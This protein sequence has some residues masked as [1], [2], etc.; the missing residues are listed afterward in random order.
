MI[1]ALVLIVL[2]VVC[3]L[4]HNSLL[5]SSIRNREGDKRM[6][7]SPFFVSW[8]AF[9]GNSICLVVFFIA[10]CVKSS[11]GKE[12]YKIPL[13]FFALALVPPICS[14]IRT[15]IIFFSYIVL[16][17]VTKE[18]Q[19]G[20]DALWI[21]F[22]VLFSF[23]FLK[24][25]KMHSSQVV[26]ITTVIVGLIAV[27]VSLFFV[28]SRDFFHHGSDDSVDSE[29][30][31]SSSFGGSN[32]WLVALAFLLLVVCE[33]LSAVETVIDEKL[34]H[35]LKAPKLLVVGFEGFC[36]L[37]LCSF[38]SL[39]VV[40]H[41]PYLYGREDILDDFNIL[42]CNS[43]L[44]FMILLYAIL[45]V[46]FNI[47]DMFFIEIT[48]AMAHNMFEEVRFF[49]YWLLTIIFITISFGFPSVVFGDIIEL[50]GFLVSTFGFLVYTTA[51]KLP[52]LKTPE[53]S[54]SI[55]SD[56]KELSAAAEETTP[57]IVEHSEL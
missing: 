38:I 35:D 31:K 42:G 13:K 45:T 55:N 4:V 57:L 33:A 34:L 29:N 46:L 20:F 16:L 30:D 14:F 9:I 3:T 51:I 6:F 24:K 1:C 27:G 2:D 53:P 5:H 17:F 32:K 49:I 8:W 47:C 10:R 40:D 23:L 43:R 21:V 41:L 54:H 52:C 26:A 11:K 39:P 22:T 15:F 12:V 56:S 44:L 28:P 19:R 50:V 48:D 7:Y 25:K 37:L 18:S 36:G